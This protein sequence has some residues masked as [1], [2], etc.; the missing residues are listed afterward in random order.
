VVKVLSHRRQE[1][2]NTCRP[3]RAYPIGATSQSERKKEQS[4]AEQRDQHAGAEDLPTT[5]S[6]L[7]LKAN[8]AASTLHTTDRSSATSQ[9]SRRYLRERG[10]LP[11][12][13]STR[14][15]CQVLATHH[16]GWLGLSANWSTPM[17]G[18]NIS[19][20]VSSVLARFRITAES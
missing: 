5:L 13:R 7:A 10:R 15:P 8:S 11:L 1:D 17:A 18:A 4:V 9:K 3:G 12:P 20:A 16:L 6:A 19:T 2:R 14:T